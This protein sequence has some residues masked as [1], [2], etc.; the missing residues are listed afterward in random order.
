VAS[1]G[2]GAVP[3]LIIGLLLSW[4]RD[5]R[6]DRARAA[7]T[8]SRASPFAGVFG[9]LTSAMAGLYL[10][11]FAAPAFEAAACHVGEMK[12]PEKSLPRA[13]FASAGIASLY[14]IVLPVIWLG[15]LGAHPI[16]GELMRTLG[17]T[18]APLLGGSAKAAAIWFMVLNMFHGTL[19]PLAGASRTFSQLSEDGLLRRVLA[20][21][22]RY[23]VPWVATVA[24]ITQTGWRSSS[25]TS[26]TSSWSTTASGTAPATR[27]SSSCRRAWTARC[28]QATRWPASAATSS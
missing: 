14:F 28:A 21:C 20:K 16:E 11:G 23:D 12:D 27:S 3:L 26:T 10:I 6:V 2:T 22:S 24:A 13:M 25:S 18:F 7:S 4:A 5:A 15:A 8:G 1:Q 19:Q 17:P 9:G